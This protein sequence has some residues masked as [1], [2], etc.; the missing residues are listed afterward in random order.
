MNPHDMV[1]SSMKGMQ[2]E[3]ENLS[4]NINKHLSAIGNYS[5]A[6]SNP[7]TNIQQLIQESAESNAG[8][9]KV[10]MDKVMEFTNKTLNKELSKTVTQLPIAMR[11]NFGDLKEIMTQDNLQQFNNISNGFFNLLSF[12]KIRIP[13]KEKKENLLIIW[14]AVF[15]TS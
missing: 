4:V 8:Y 2:T 14:L 12:K 1:Q 10:I 9:T 7:S 15:N 11:S 6:V 3:I 5:D 13:K